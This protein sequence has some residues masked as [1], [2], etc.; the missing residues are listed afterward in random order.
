[1]LDF[2]SSNRLTVKLR[3]GQIYFFALDKALYSNGN[4][5]DTDKLTGKSW[6]A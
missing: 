1:M 2:R 3:F 4:V 5:S 6:Y